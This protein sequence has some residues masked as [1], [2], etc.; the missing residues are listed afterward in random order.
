VATPVP[1][2]NRL[3]M[4]ASLLSLWTRAIAISASSSQVR[5]RPNSQNAGL[6]CQSHPPQKHDGTFSHITLVEEDIMT[7]GA[8]HQHRRFSRLAIT[9]GATVLAIGLLTTGS[10]LYS[11]NDASAVT[12][13][14]FSAFTRAAEAPATLEIVPSPVMDTNSEFFFGTG[15]GSVGYYAERPNQ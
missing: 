8:T 14:T 10:V 7:V 2:S 6:C 5:P 12:T 9:A 3:R 4:D 11:T 13:S 15:D 1:K